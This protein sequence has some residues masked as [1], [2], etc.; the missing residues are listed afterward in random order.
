MKAT[1]EIK[2]QISSAHHIKIAFASTIARFERKQIPGVQSF[3]KADFDTVKEAQ[4][5][6]RL[7]Y[8]VMKQEG[9]ITHYDRFD[10]GFRYDAAEARIKRNEVFYGVK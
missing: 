3:Y 8:N 9:D 1:I 7:A 6:L 5:A 10:D 4:S 2:G